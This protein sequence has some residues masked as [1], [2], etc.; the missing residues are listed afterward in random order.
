[1]Q[2]AINMM[3]SIPHSEKKKTNPKLKRHYFFCSSQNYTDVEIKNPQ[4]T[5][6]K[7]FKENLVILF[8]FHSQITRFISTKTA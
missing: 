3:P 2:N 4:S 1:M 7:L 6:Q 8:L 5:Q